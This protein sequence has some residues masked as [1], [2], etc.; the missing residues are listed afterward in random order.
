MDNKSATTQSTFSELLESDEDEPEVHDGKSLYST[1][2]VGGIECCNVDPL[3]R[4]GK[5]MQVF[6]MLIL[7]LFPLVALIVKDT[8]VLFELKNIKHDIDG[9]NKQV[10]LSLSKKNRIMKIYLKNYSLCLKAF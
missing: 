1:V 9:A 7:P 3:S 6:Q 8:F 10:I 4:K 5:C 2:S